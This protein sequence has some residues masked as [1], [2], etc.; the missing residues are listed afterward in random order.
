MAGTFAIE[1]TSAIV[2]EEFIRKILDMQLTIDR[3]TA[4]TLGL[5]LRLCNLQPSAS[6]TQTESMPS[7]LT[8]ISA[9]SA[10]QYPSAGFQVSAPAPQ[11]QPTLLA[12]PPHF[13]KPCRSSQLYQRGIPRQ[14]FIQQRPRHSCTSTFLLHHCR[15]DTS[16]ARRP[17][18]VTLTL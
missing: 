4:E 13:H 9:A 17:I 5:R 6:P 10:P 18:R 16:G 12:R 7:T 14:L 15:S 11:L 1:G 2:M 3:L 8:A